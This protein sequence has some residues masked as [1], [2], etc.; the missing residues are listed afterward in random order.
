MDQLESSPFEIQMDLVT[1]LG[2]DSIEIDHSIDVVDHD[3]T[4]MS[5]SGITVSYNHG[6][7]VILYIRINCCRRLNAHTLDRIEHDISDML[8]FTD[9]FFKSRKVE[10]FGAGGNSYYR[11]EYQI[12]IFRLND[13]INK[14]H[15]YALI[16]VDKEFIEAL[17]TKLTED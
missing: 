12:K 14:L 4:V 10:P 3:N 9:G 6:P 16:K 1:I 15:Q 7:D 13:F 2:S 8:R 5:M 11:A 17:E